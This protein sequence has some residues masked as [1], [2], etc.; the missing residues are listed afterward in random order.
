MATRWSELKHDILTRRRSY[1]EFKVKA[2][3]LSALVR[4]TK[5]SGFFAKIFLLIDVW[6]IVQSVNR[7][8][9]PTKEN[10]DKQNVHVLIDFWDNFEK[11]NMTRQ[12]LFRA[13]RRI[14]LSECEHDDVYE[15]RHDK[16][17]WDMISAVQ[18]GRYKL[19]TVHSPTSHWSDPAAIEALG[20]ARMEEAVT[21]TLS[22]RGR[23][24]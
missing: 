1:F 15:E 2:P 11:F 22:K 23:I 19:P 17:L 6:R 21:G 3:L 24:K 5:R 18:D 9:E 20:F 10:S 13:V 7:Y 8:P 14:H 12:E 16:F 4:C